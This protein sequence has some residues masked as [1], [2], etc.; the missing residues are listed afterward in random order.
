[1]GLLGFI[2]IFLCT[3]IPFRLIVNSIDN[4]KS[5]PDIDLSNYRPLDIYNN[6]GNDSATPVELDTGDDM[7]YEKEAE[8]RGI[9]VTT[10]K[11]IKNLERQNA[12]YKRKMNQKKENVRNIAALFEGFITC[13]FY[14]F[15]FLLIS[16]LL[17]KLFGVTSEDVAVFAFF[18][19]LGLSVFF[20]ETLLEDKLNFPT[21]DESTCWLYFGITLFVENIFLMFIKMPS[22]LENIFPCIFIHIII[23]IIIILCHLKLIIS[24]LK[25]LKVFGFTFFTILLCIIIM[26][27]TFGEIK[28]KG[29]AHEH[30]WVYSS[31]KSMY[32]DY[33]IYACH[34]CEET[35][36][37]TLLKDN[38]HPEDTLED[39][40]FSNNVT[41]YITNSG[42]KYHS[43]GCQYLSSSKYSVS[44][45]EAISDG[46]SPCSRCNPP[47]E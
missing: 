36:Q 38:E 34:D 5:E 40:N 27:F 35:S 12:E 28:F 24:I 47:T 1:M 16:Y 44:L 8:E 37:G 22:S 3:Y 14:L 23:S 46:Y 20:H 30:D 4:N 43:S 15:T 18:I 2:L 13:S 9:D 45:E 11:E 6:Y 10:L 25:S 26:L 7:L 32:S 41:V 42:S 19:S 17:A 31:N 33:R 21:T 29:V 39:D